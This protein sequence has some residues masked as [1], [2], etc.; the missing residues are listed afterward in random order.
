MAWAVSP[1]MLQSGALL[2]LLPLLLAAWAVAKAI[3]FL[4]WRPR[5][6]ERML[7]SQGLAGTPYR[8]LFGDLK[9]MGRLTEEAESKPMPLLSHNIAPRVAAFLTR[10]TRELGERSRPL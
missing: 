5:Q 9:E 10:K 2:W 4:W 6:L 7:R 8:F 1:A 3:N